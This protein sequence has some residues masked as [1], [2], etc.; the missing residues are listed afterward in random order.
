MLKPLGAR[1]T[2][3]VIEPENIPN[4]TASGLVLPDKGKRPANQAIV[5]ALGDGVTLKVKRGDKVWIREDTAAKLNP[6]DEESLIDEGNVVAVIYDNG[7]E[8]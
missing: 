8:L 4:T 2:I 3:K 1:L 7:I 5:I 6:E